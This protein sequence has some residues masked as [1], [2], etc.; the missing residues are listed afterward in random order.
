MNYTAVVPARSGSK[1]LPHKNIKLLGDKPLLVWTLE[2][3]IHSE[4]IDEVILS[5]DSMEYWKIANNHLKSRKLTLDF[6]E[7]CDAGDTVKIFDYLKDKRT[8]LFGQRNGAFMLALPT[9]PLRQVRHVEEAIALFETSGKPVFSATNYGFPISFS[10]QIQES[11][12][13]FPVF[14]DSPMVTGNT[15]SQNQ[16]DCYHPNGA[17]Y[18]R[19]IKDLDRRDLMTLYTDAVPYFMSRTASIDIDADHDFKIAEALL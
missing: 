10:F 14:S 18:V 15:R 12:I 4:R 2:A 9:V 6:R 16:Q 8:K 3:C 13:W 19:N 11:G 7:P 17:I 5:T 1:R